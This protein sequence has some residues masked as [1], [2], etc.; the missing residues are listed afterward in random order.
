MA[1]ENERM[2]S[3]QLRTLIDNVLQDTSRDMMEQCDVVDTAFAK[4]VEEMEDA[5]A[6]MEENLRK[7]IISL[8]FYNNI[9]NVRVDMCKACSG[10]SNQKFK[11]GYDWFRHRVRS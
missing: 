9:L 6:K 11:A 10:K 5:K 4:R 8:L 3:I 2:A 7:V 1:A